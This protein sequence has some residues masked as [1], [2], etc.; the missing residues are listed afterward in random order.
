[1]CQ[2][3]KMLGSPM[4]NLQLIQAKLRDMFLDIDAS[5]HLIYRVCLDKDNSTYRI[6]REAAMAKLFAS[7]SEQQVIDKA[8]LIFGGSGVVSGFVVEQLYQ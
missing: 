7:E 8:V 5:A 3:R 6:P 2:N 1:M 4:I